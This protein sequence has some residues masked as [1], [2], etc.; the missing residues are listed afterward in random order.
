[1]NGEI[2]RAEIKAV[3][4]ED[5]SFSLRTVSFSDLARG[6]AAV[7]SVK[8]DGQQVPSMMSGEELEEW[9][10]VL[11]GMKKVRGRRYKGKVI[12]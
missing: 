5:V 12:V 1:M 8:R 9:R 3:L 6:E 10:D 4:P 7:L 11:E 2:S